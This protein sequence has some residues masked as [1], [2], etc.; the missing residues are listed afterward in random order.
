[1]TWRKAFAFSLR[2]R[3]PALSRRRR[4]LRGDL[5]AADKAGGFVDHQA[6]RFDVA[7]HGAAGAQFAAL[8]RGDVPVHGAV[9]DDRAGP[10]VAFDPGLLADG[11]PAIR[12]DLAVD[13]AIDQ[14]FFLKFYRALDRNAAR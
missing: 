2:A 8:S 13:F 9:N 1:M 6:R 10:N 11:E 12:I 3:R 5:R 14:E 7:I 4:L